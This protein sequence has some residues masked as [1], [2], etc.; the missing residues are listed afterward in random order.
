MITIKKIESPVLVTD[1]ENVISLG[2]GQTYT[3]T[4]AIVPAGIKY[5]RFYHNNSKVSVAIYDEAWMIGNNILDNYTDP[6]NPLYAQRLDDS[7]NTGNTLL[8]DN[9]FGN[10]L[11]FT[12]ASGLVANMNGYF[13]VID[14]LTGLAFSSIAM[15]NSFDNVMGATGLLATFNTQSNDGYNDWFLATSAIFWR[16]SEQD[17]STGGSLYSKRTYHWNTST[18]LSNFTTS[19]LYF[20][21]N[22]R[23]FHQ[24]LTSVRHFLPTR[25][26][27]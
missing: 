8:Y 21:G 5:E 9:A 22:A 17:P 3:C 25:I 11:R 12:D 20:N 10:R 27:F 6:T 4:T 7:D 19:H 14:N 18:I 16:L 23:F 13:Y 2:A 24:V 1:G 26:H 15:S